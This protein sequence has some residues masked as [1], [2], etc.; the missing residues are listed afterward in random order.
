MYMDDWN[1]WA[2]EKG[3]TGE[4]RETERQRYQSE[5]AKYTRDFFHGPRVS[6]GGGHSEPVFAACNP[7]TPE[8]VYN[9]RSWDSQK[10]RFNAANADARSHLG[11]PSANEQASVSV[12]V[13]GIRWTGL[14]SELRE[15]AARHRVNIQFIS[16]GHSLLSEKINF[17]VAGDK[18]N[19]TAFIAEYN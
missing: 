9:G 18:T 11:L 13:S 12:S 4:H 2:D 15:R 7:P 16:R 19:V 14:E 3:L 10:Q 6:I 8:Q 5:I 17:Y 1:K